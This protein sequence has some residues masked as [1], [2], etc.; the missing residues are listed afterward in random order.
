MSK[1]HAENDGKSEREMSC[2]VVKNKLHLCYVKS[3]CTRNAIYIYIY[4]YMSHHQAF[5][6]TD[7]MYQNL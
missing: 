7:P 2:R 3:W 4:I 1:T 5:Q 6:R